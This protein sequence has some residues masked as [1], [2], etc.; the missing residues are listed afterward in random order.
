M[1]HFWFGKATA[2]ETLI[3]NLWGSNNLSYPTPILSRAETSYKEMIQISRMM[4]KMCMRSMLV[5]N[6][7]TLTKTKIQKFS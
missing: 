3:K 2:K 7:F 1:V 6:G 4:S 5:G